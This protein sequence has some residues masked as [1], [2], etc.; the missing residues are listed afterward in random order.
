MKRLLKG[1]H[2]VD[3]LQGIDGVRDVLI[4]GDRV[5]AVGQDLPAGPGVEVIEVPAGFVVCPGFVDMHV[6]LREPGQEHKETIA[7]GTA[8]AAAGGFTA[9]RLHA[10]HQ[11]GQ[12][13]APRVTRAILEKAA[14]RGPGAG[15]PDRRRVEG[16]EGREPVGD[17]RPAGRR[18]ASAFSDDG[19]PVM[20]AL[21]MRRAL[22]YAGMLEH[23]GHRPLRGAD[24]EGRRRGA[25]GLRRVAARPARHPGRRRV[26][27]GGARHRAGRDDRQRRPHRAPEHPAGAARRVGG[28]GRAA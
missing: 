1:G 14:A 22:E 5:A 21:L 3:P 4:E 19:K 15:L 26:D 28:A 7:T 6:H 27:H 23:A 13:H 10:E 20:T 2:L 17:G 8:A 11:P 9:R 16:H 12:R 24:A 25:R 18:A